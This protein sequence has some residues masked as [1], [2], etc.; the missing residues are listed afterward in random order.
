MIP[1]LVTLKAKLIAGG[2]VLAIIIAVFGAQQFRI[3]LLKDDIKQKDEKIAT[4]TSDLAVA[5][6]NV[7]V[8]KAQVER[9]N[10]AIGAMKL[11]KAAL[12][13]KVRES[14]L[15]AQKNKAAIVSIEGTGVDS[16]NDFFRRLFQ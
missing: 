13:A 10:K 5:N 11:E 3:S 8:L 2:I 4:L 16:M 12:D 9:Q 14:A 15:Q 1:N 6:A 7:A